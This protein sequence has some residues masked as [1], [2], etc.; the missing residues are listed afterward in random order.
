[1]Y[2]VLIA[3]VAACFLLSGTSALAATP[4]SE[5]D[6]TFYALGVILARDLGPLNLNAKE[7]EMVA[8]GLTDAALGKDSQVDLPTYGPKVQALAQARVAATA[9]SEKEA[10]DAFVDKMA[11]TKG[12]EKTASGLVYIVLEEGT[13]PSPTASDT[14]KVHYHGTLRDGTVFDS[15]VDRG[16]PV[17]FPL[18]GVIPCWTEGVQ[19]MKV[20]GK[21][22]LVCPASIA[23][24]DRGAGSKV[25]PGAALNFEVELLE[26]E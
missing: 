11:A 15:S 2:R 13:G 24:G 5:D 10:A 12:A 21:S 7:M 25:K 16:E 6:K 18:D 3:A 17:S 8:S 1:M 4:K 26:I 23:Y 20:G 9:S 22:R 14:V 19:K